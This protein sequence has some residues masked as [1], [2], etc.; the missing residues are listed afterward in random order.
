MGKYFTA[1]VIALS[2]NVMLMMAQI[3]IDNINPDNENT[4]FNWKDSTIGSLDK[5]NFNLDSTAGREIPE[6]TS[7][8]S[9]FFKT[10]L[11]EEAAEAFT[12]FFKTIGNWFK[13][14]PIGRLT[15]GTLTAVPNYLKLVFP[16]DIAFMLGSIWHLL[17]GFLLVQVMFGRD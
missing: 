15:Y 8:S 1:L 17:T 16:P 5:G 3:S 11:G 4:F 10:V 9:G 6:A 12:D 14:N 7:T 13:T 2:I